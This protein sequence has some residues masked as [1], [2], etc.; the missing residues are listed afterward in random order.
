[1]D[2]LPNQGPLSR[3]YTNSRNFFWDISFVPDD[4]DLRLFGLELV[5]PTHPYE[6]L[7]WATFQ[8]TQEVVLKKEESWLLRSQQELEEWSLIPRSA[9]IP[10]LRGCEVRAFSVSPIV[11]PLP[12]FPLLLFPSFLPFFHSQIA[13]YR[14]TWYTL[15]VARG[16]GIQKW[17]NNPQSLSK[18][19]IKDNHPSRAALFTL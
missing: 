9:L 7:P 10:A 6:S 19:L 15:H 17:R 8:V 12:S 18:E 3:D 4:P 5:P 11:L 2:H 1:M 16:K 14:R 13:L